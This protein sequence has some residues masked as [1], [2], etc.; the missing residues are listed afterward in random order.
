MKVSFVVPVYKKSQEQ[1]KATLESLR[2]QSHKDIEVV[3]V[4]DGA[5]QDLE[6][7]VDQTFKKDTRFTMFVVEHGGAPK[8]RNFGFTKTTGD[9]VSF[10]DADCYAEPEMTKMWV[11]TFER[12]PN[13]DFVYSGY[14]WTNPKAPGF[15]SEIFDPWLLGQ[16]N[17]ICS[18]FP[19]K[20]DRFPGWDESLTGLQDWDYWRRAVN[21]GCVG[22]YIPGYGFATDLPDENSISGNSGKTKERVERIREKFN[23]P[24]RDILVFGGLYKREAI[25]LAKVLDA[26]YFVNWPFYK[27]HDYKMVFMVGFHPWELKGAA[28]LFNSLGNEKRV[29]YWMGQ[30]SEMT[31]CAPYHEAKIFI[32][33]IKKDGM[34]SFCESERTRKILEDMGIEAEILPFPAEFGMVQSTMPEKFKVLALSDDQFKGHLDAIVKAL[35]NIDI[36]VANME[37]PYNIADYAVGMQFTQYPRLL[38]N[39]QKMLMNGRYMISNVQEPYSGYV[40]TSDVTKFKSEVIA[41]LV[42]LEKNHPLNEDASKYYMETSDKETFSKKVKSVI[43]PILEVVQ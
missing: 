14:K 39:S 33:K 18:M 13:A 35:P 27:I 10:W 11:K 9:V 38:Q 36:T 41:K 29:I 1:V 28:S 25:H 16:Y 12:N 2:T 8:A 24:K 5:D 31:Y 34:V 30:D 4:F 3:V 22:K 7:V 23:D 40:D 26:D 15:D 42:E 17:F 20:R 37:T 21:A 43:A 32:E 6:H 19:I